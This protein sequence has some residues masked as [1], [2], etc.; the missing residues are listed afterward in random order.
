MRLNRAF[1]LSVLMALFTSAVKADDHTPVSP[2][3][4]WT[5]Q[6]IVFKDGQQQAFRAGLAKFMDS[7]MGKSM[8]GRVFWWIVSDGDAPA[9]VPSYRFSSGCLDE[10]NVDSSQQQH[11]GKK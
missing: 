5:A 10:W 11:N 6:N 4:V 7:N 9:T 3:N 1:F 2:T 8:P